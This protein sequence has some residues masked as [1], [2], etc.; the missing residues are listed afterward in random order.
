MK[1]LTGKEFFEQLNSNSLKQPL[2]IKGIVKKSENNSDVLFKGSGDSSD[3]VKIPSSMVES[4]KLMKTYTREGASMA[5]VEITLK[6]ST[7]PESK[8]LAELLSFT[9]QCKCKECNC[10]KSEHCQNSGENNVCGHCGCHKDEHHCKCGHRAEYSNSN[11][12]FHGSHQ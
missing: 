1:T 6:E 10:N 9:E 8:V 4:V 11:C 7:N 5:I 2:I 3:W 12:G